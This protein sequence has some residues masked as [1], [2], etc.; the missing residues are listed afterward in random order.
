MPLILNVNLLRKH[1][2]EITRASWLK[3]VFLLSNYIIRSRFLSRDGSGCNPSQL[4]R[5]EIESE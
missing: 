1:S 4:S 2:K 3:I 5:I